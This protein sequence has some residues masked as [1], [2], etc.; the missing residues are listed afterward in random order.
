VNAIQYDHVAENGR[1]RVSGQRLI[2]LFVDC[3]LATTAKSWPEAVRSRGYTG[4]KLHFIPAYCPHLDPPSGYGAACTKHVSPTIDV[5]TTFADFKA[6]ILTFLREE[7][8]RWHTIVIQ[9]TDQLYHLA[10]RIFEGSDLSRI[11]Y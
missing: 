8:R 3:A 1:G 2:H 9:V 6:E 4:S 11:V 7:V 10:K 5:I